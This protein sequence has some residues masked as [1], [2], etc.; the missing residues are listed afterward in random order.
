MLS[1]KIQ[2]ASDALAVTVARPSCTLPLLQ[3]LKP[4]F[5]EQLD[6]MRRANCSIAAAK[7]VVRTAFFAAPAN[8][9]GILGMNR[10]LGHGT[11]ALPDPIVPR[12]SKDGCD[13][14]HRVVH[15]CVPGVKH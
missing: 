3:P 5:S 10:E 13:S 7:I 8:S 1:E 11:L 6:R 2:V 4:V 14:G 12:R 9:L 15:G